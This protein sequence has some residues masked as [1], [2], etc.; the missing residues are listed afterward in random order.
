MN[1]PILDIA[2]SLSHAFYPPADPAESFAGKTI[3]VTGANTGVGFEAAAKF[4]TLGASRVILGIRNA[5]KGEQAKAE[6]E[7]RTGTSEVVEVWPL[8]MGS[9]DSVRAFAQR[10][11]ALDRLDAAVL[12][13]GVYMVDFQRS[14]YGW[15]ETLQVNVLSTALLA[16][17]LLPKLRASRRSAE[18]P[19]LAIVG[20]GK[21]RMMSLP[22]KHR[23]ATNMLESF[24]TPDAFQE[25]RQ[26]G[27]SKVLV[28]L[29]VQKLAALAQPA[30]GAEPQPLR[31]TVVSVCPGFARSNLA[32]GHMTWFLPR[33]GAGLVLGLLARTTEQGARSLVSSVLLGPEANG[34]FWQHDE[35]QP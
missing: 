22:P 35:L 25:S 26:Y 18:P 33:L 10:A 30:A 32:R 8:E 7:A 6:I 34:R 4:T 27:V 21:H 14:A 5:A 1:I 20:S 11:A 29:L 12:N 31:V 13:A 9:Y 19:V 24:N 3:L 23:Q 16:V 17:L 15:E 2:R 28:Q